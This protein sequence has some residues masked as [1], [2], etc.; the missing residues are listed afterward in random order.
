MTSSIYYP[1]TESKI[2][3]IFLFIISNIFLIPVILLKALLFSRFLKTVKISAIIALVS[4]IIFCGFLAFQINKEASER[5]LI[6]KYEVELNKL[7]SENQS[8]E[9]QFSKVNAVKGAS[10]LA[11]KLN[12]EK[13]NQISYIKLANN[14]VVKK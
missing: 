6:R 3:F 9:S 8:L 4:A 10:D 7:A 2:V 13:V 12:F 1:K 14:K 5:Y 11:Q